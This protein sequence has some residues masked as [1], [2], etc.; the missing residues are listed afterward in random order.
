MKL[1]GD[2]VSPFVRMSMVTAHE[3][4]WGKRV[5]L[6]EA[7][8]TPV[9]ENTELARY[10]PIAKVPVL[11]TEHNHALYDSRVII[12]YICHVSGNRVL[13]PDDGVKRF[14]ILTLLA[15]GQGIA[16]SGVAYRYETAMR[17]AELQWKDYM[18]RLER[19]VTAAFD[20]LEANWMKELSEIT[21]GSISVAVA[22]SYLD[23]RLPSWRWR[24]GRP[25]LTAFHNDFSG[26][27]SMKATALPK[28]A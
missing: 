12:E 23:Y 28:A 13:I 20:D 11:V 18:T 7:R 4:G 21:A 6:T 22:L 2:L 10:S 25:K 15:L 5:I 9:A 27:E 19:R 8:V 24:D 14:R 17:P 1:L 3:V 26:R 16:E